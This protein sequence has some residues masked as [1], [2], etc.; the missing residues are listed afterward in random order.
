MKE[1]EDVINMIFNSNNLESYQIRVIIFLF[2][3]AFYFF[4]NAFFFI[5]IYIS[6]VFYVILIFS[7]L[8]FL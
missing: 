6:I 5:D 1:K 7:F 2:G 3:M 8:Y 4:V